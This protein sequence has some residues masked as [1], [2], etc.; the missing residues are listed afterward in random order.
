MADPI[1]SDDRPDIVVAG[2]PK[3]GT[4][5][6]ATLLDGHHRVALMEPKEP[7]RFS[8]G[9]DPDIPEHN[10]ASALP[11]A[12]YRAAV[13]AARGPGRLVIDA[14]T[15]YC[16][17]AVIAGTARRLRGAN[18]DLKVFLM[19]RDPVKRLVSDW[20]MRHAEGWART[21][22]RDEVRANLGPLA[23]AVGAR[24]DADLIA[25]MATSLDWLGPDRPVDRGS[26]SLIACGFYDPLIAVYREVF[27]DDLLV[28]PSEALRRD[29]ERVLARCFAHLGLDPEPVSAGDDEFNVGDHR[30]E[31]VVSR[32]L[33]RT[34]IAGA[35]HAL[36][37]HRL[38][39]RVRHALTRPTEPGIE[40]LAGSPEGAVMDR[41]YARLSADTAAAMERDFGVRWG[42]SRPA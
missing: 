13:A 9:L 32:W 10:R 33:R 28:V 30:R 11:A 12:A 1:R 37:P 4:T 7:H 36:L 16:H 39:V 14:S 18:P 3:A 26:I 19:V 17:P 31:T 27:G 24:D 6:L 35:A 42:L 2:F 15:S 41:L 20:R 22:L 21:R 29:Q 5:A 25:R 40:D 8:W 23:V 34:G 38:I